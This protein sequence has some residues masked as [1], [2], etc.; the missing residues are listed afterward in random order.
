MEIEIPLPGIVPLGLK[1][2]LRIPVSTAETK[3][4]MNTQKRI[5]TFAVEESRKLQ[6]DTLNQEE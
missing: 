6:T 1:G 2:A 4:S 5:A 3:F